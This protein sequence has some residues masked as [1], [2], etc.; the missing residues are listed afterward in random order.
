MSCD[1]VQRYAK[2]ASGVRHSNGDQKL[3]DRNR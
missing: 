1:K 2:T 3:S